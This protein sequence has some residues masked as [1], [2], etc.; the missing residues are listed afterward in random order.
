MSTTP[1]NRVARCP[2]TACALLLG[3]SVAQAIATFHTH[4]SN[5]A[6]AHTLTLLGDA[7]YVTVPN[8]Q[9]LETLQGLGPAFLG[10]L[11]FTLS[12]G[13]ALS[14]LS[15]AGAWVWDRVFSR[16]KFSLAFLMAPILVFLILLNSRGFCPVESSYFI[17]IPIG[18]F[19]AAQKWTPRQP[20]RWVWVN[21]VVQSLSLV[22]LAILW[23]TQMDGQ[24]FLR[25]RDHLLL[26]NRPGMAIN[27]FYYTY[28]LY[29]AQAFKSLDQKTLKTCSL[30]LSEKTSASHLLENELLAH[31]Y[32][33]VDK[34]PGRDLTIIEK[35][36]T[37]TFFNDGH[38]ILKTTTKHFLS[39]PNR[40][41]K[42]FS[43]KADRYG[44]F[45]QF[46]FLGILLGFPL[47]LFFLL[48]T[49]LRLPGSLLI[50][51]NPASV[52]ASILCLFVG[53]ALWIP[54]YL[55]GKGD[56]NVTDVARALESHRWQSRVSAL[57][58]AEK[59]GIEIGNLPGYKKILTSPHI[60]ERYWLA[61]ALGVSRISHTYEDLLGLLDDPQPNVVCMALFSLGKRGDQRAV[62]K[63]L[64]I[65]QT[66]HHWY[67][68]WYAYRALRTLGWR[69]S[70]S[71]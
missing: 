6:L 55:G 44:V 35:G 58:V 11:F 53:V 21:R 22:L 17:A 32:L 33:P 43:S 70:R 15:I 10:G 13:A 65:I 41:L 46:T 42:T 64:K 59:K 9:I 38:E 1:M 28:S 60:A 18:V 12:V 66:S 2:Y 67:T 49:L 50:G 14:I 4:L 71:L 30:H 19:I 3:L 23:M 68:Q 48:H 5:A 51:W 20:R 29:P 8:R 7:G 37:L 62:K 27:D 25:I 69:Q 57:R 26:S 39:Y 47:T 36:G 16:N 61:K 40:V 24:M 56:S 54:V 63:I 31:D 52:V 45:R 34:G